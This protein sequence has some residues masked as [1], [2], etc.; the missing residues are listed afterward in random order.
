MQFKT[1]IYFCFFMALG[2]QVLLCQSAFGL[3]R[4][5]DIPLYYD[6]RT[7][8]LTIDTTRV[9]SFGG[10][11]FEIP[12]DGFVTENFTPFMNTLF[13]MA[14]PYQ[15]GE[16]NFATVTP[17]VYS[18]GNV[19]PAGLTPDELG[20]Y[21]GPHQAYPTQ[22]TPYAYLAVGTGTGTYQVF[23]PFYSPS[24]YPALN[25]PTVGPQVID[26]WAEAAR[27][28]YNAATG[29]LILDSTVE[30]GG[31]L[32]G[33]S[34][35]FNRDMI[36]VDSFAGIAE[37]PGRVLETRTIV[38]VGFS[39]IPEGVYALGP[40]LPEGL[41]EAAFFESLNY[42]R[43]IGEPGHGAGALDLDVSGIEMS[44][45]FMVPEPSGV[46]LGLIAAS[47][48]LLCRRSGGI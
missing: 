19:L 36:D 15:I 44:L 31:T 37:E 8:N 27:L 46:F 39:G 10:Y 6:V 47:L 24:P 32:W 34:L 30:N 43:F 42:A 48:L 35:Y 11:G 14:E 20:T 26:N 28:T 23:E 5:E 45:G 12:F 3:E 17:G 9:D 18:L 33:Y 1:F 2:A 29:D 4:G 16:S 22:T 25:D 40:V 41:S 7:G 38:E 13:Y 21:F